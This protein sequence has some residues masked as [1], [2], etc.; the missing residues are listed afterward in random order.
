M[1]IEMTNKYII[2]IF[3]KIKYINKI[4]IKINK[5]IIKY[6]FVICNK[7]WIIKLIFSLFSWL[8]SICLSISSNSSWALNDKCNILNSQIEKFII[9]KIAGIKKGISLISIKYS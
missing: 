9:D 6:N 8:F 3:V 2:K 4:D 7:S 5:Y 1:K